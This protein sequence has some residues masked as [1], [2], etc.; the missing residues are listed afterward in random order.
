MEAYDKYVKGKTTGQ[1]ITDN[2]TAKGKADAKSKTIA[3]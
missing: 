3:T 1:G 2:R